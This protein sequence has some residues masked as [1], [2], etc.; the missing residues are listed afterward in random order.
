MTVQLV[1]QTTSLQ[2]KKLSES[3]NKWNQASTV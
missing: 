2:K 1:T 3:M